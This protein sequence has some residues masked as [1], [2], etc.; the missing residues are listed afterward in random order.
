MSSAYTDLYIDA[1]ADFSTTFDLVADDGT[2]I[3]IQGYS[4]RSQIRKSYYSANATANLT[5]TTVDAS[6]G[7]TIISIDA[8]NTANIFPGRYV[9]DIKMID[10]SNTTTRILEGIATITPQATQ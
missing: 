5:I 10:T 6:N 8:A 7:N 2:P 1:G 3:N 4:F 9:Y